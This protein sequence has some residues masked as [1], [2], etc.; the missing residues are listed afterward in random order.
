M[1]FQALL[2][3]STLTS[4]AGLRTSIVQTIQT[5]ADWAWNPDSAARD[6]TTNLFHFNSSGAAARS[7]GLPALVQDQGAL[8]QIYALLASAPA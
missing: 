8:V 1:C 6:A 2:V 4:D 7:R 3:L 5:Y